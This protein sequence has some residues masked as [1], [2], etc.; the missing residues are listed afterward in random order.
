MSLNYLRE[1]FFGG[2]EVIGLMGRKDQGELKAF[3]RPLWL[4]KQALTSELRYRWGRLT[5]PPEDWIVWFKWSQR[6]WGQ[7]KTYGTRS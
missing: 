6:S 7:I 1:Y 4:W 3:G 2:G 5:R